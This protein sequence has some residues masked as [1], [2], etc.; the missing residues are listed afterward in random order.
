MVAEAALDFMKCV[1]KLQFQ[2][3]AYCYTFHDRFN[4]LCDITHEPIC[5]FV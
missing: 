4:S 1:F 2:W 3:K 5:I